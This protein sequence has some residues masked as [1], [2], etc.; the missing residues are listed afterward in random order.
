MSKFKKISLV[1][2]ILISVIL[3]SSTMYLAIGTG[4]D[5]YGI[6]VDNITKDNKTL[7]ITGSTSNSALSYAG[8]SY[9]IKGDSLYLKLRYSLGSSFH[10]GGK[11]NITLN[12]DLS[13]I[14]NMYLQGNKSE[15]EKL[16]WIKYS[17]NIKQN[18]LQ[19]QMSTENVN[20]KSTIKSIKFRIINNGDTLV[21][22]GEY[23]VLQKDKD[24]KW[25]DIPFKKDSSFTA[26]MILLKPKGKYE[27]SILLSPSDFTFNTGKYR[28]NKVISTKDKKKDNI[29]CDFN[30]D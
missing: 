16:F 6:F 21:T 9:K 12:N 18:N 25:F 30:I 28:I 10:Q 24:G 13:N 23:Y 27:S 4:I 7:Q 20:Y 1:I 17:Q 14:N 8:Y 19:V 26:E 3:I 15:D 5:T 29:S 11:F 22:L 2:I